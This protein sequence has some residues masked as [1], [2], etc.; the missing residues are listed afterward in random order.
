M[1]EHAIVVWTY[2]FETIRRC[3]GKTATD[4]QFS[5]L[6]LDMNGAYPDEFEYVLRNFVMED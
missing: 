1:N 4:Y 5:R 2:L 6:I 3:K